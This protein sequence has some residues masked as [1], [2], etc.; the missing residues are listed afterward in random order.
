MK[1]NKLAYKEWS[2]NYDNKKYD[3]KNTFRFKE[4]N[5]GGEHASLVAEA[6]S[7][8]SEHSNRH[9]ERPEMKKKMLRSQ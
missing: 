2:E 9:S 1:N 6:I 3:N 5:D 4:R 8:L 7:E